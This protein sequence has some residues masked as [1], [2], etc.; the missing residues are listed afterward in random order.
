MTG[1]GAVA[2]A[3]VLALSAPAAAAPDGFEPGE[4]RPGGETT[5]DKARDRNA[6]SHSSANMAFDRE[7][8]FKVGN[9]FFRRLWVSAPSS[10]KAADG[11]GP[12]FNE[13]AC[14]SCHLKDGRGHP[15]LLEAGDDRGAG[16]FLR[17]SIPPRNAEEWRTLADRQRTVIPDPVYGT[18]LQDRAIQG[19]MP[20]GRMVVR[21]AE[22][23]VTLAD[24]ETVSLRRP[25]YDVADWGYGPPHPDVMLSPRIAPPM[26]GVGLLEAI[27][28]EAILVGA[29]PHDR[30]GDGISGRPQWVRDPATGEIALGRFGWKAG[31]PSVDAQGQGAFA[32]DIGIS[33]PFNPDPWG[34]CSEAQADCRAA[35]HGD[36]PQYANL[37]AHQDV[38]DLV[39]FYS[40]HLAL[41]A[42]PD[43]D[44]PPVLAGK[45]VFRDLGCSGCH[46]PT[47]TTAADAADP[48]L[49][50]QTIWPYTDLL[51]HDMGPGLADGRPEGEASGQE[52]RTA[53]LWGLGLTATVGGGHAFFLH[54]GRA[55][56]LTEAILWHGGEAEP[57]REGF[58]AL[59]A[60]DRADLLRFLNSL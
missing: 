52:W 4:D 47:H 22:E 59:P 16:M 24:G 57:A 34:D 5:H 37:E 46:T 40:R 26:V 32:G 48:E 23:T 10:T 43:A 35:P 27:P 3:A 30:D 45:A 55:R 19:H 39:L 2:M 6:F 18:Q 42:R 13:A 20:E 33:T 11:L 38:T 36:D 28:A 31:N 56:T 21:Y 44:D 58:R 8:D 51:L 25:T 53:P 7:M 54:D 1:A 12:L 17:L 15:P 29:D 50:G 14:Q 49:A 9:G 41:P 60:E